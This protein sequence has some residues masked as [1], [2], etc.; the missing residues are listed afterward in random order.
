ML[1]HGEWVSI[2]SRT[3][4]CGRLRNDN[5]ISSLSYCVGPHF[6]VIGT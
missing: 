2:D 4:V 6:A 5:A 3:C 1:T